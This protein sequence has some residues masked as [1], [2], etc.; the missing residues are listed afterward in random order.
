MDRLAGLEAN[1]GGK[2]VGS[3][4]R[5]PSSLSRSGRKLPVRFLRVDQDESCDRYRASA[6]IAA[7]RRSTWAGETK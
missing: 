1:V 5:F 2:L 3:E 7:I 4:Q 6:A